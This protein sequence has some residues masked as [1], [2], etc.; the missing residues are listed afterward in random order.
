MRTQSIDTSPDV[1]QILIAAIR[2][3]SIP[4]RFQ[5]IQSLSQTMAFSSIQAWQKQHPG[6]TE[7]EAIAHYVSCMYGASLAT[8]VR[9]ALWQQ[10]Q[11]HFQSVDLL[12]IALPALRILDEM[13][14]SCY[15]G[16]SIASSLHGMQ[17]FAQDID[18]VIALQGQDLSA[19]IEQLKPHYV[20]DTQIARRAIQEHASFSFIHLASLKKVDIIIPH[21]DVFGHSMHQ[22]VTLHILDERY[23]PVRVASAPE[24]ILWKLQRYNQNEKVMERGMKDDAEWNDVIGMLKVQGSDL[25]IA[26]LRQWAKTFHILDELQQALEDAGLFIPQASER[27]AISPNR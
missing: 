21:A 26:L 23:P 11:W 27:I 13:G 5:L 1:E 17:Q 2:Q 16:G 19:L 18:L 25:S 22:L 8:C 9:Q 10:E 12:A 3:A 14:I 15:L 4:K 6:K 7:Q 20:I 24:M